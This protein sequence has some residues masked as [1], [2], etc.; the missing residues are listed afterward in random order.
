MHAHASFRP[1]MRNRFDQLTKLVTRKAYSPGGMV[2]TDAEVSPDAKRIDI[3]FTPDPTLPRSILDAILDPLGLLGRI[4]RTPVTIEP[5][6]EPPDGLE[7]MDCVIKHHIFRRMLAARDPAP[8]LPR[9]WILSA[10]R[11]SLALAG[12]WFRKSRRWGPGIY[13][14]PPLTYT[15]LV[16]IREL[17]VRRDTLLVRLMGAGSTLRKA[18]A[19]LD[20]LPEDAPERRVAHQ[21]LL[22]LG[23]EATADATRRTKEDEEFIMA[24]QEIVE[25][26]LA[27]REEQGRQQGRKEELIEALLAV[28]KARFGETPR[29]IVTAVES[30]HDMSVLR[31]WR[32]LVATHSADEIAAA[33]CAP[34]ARPPVPARAAIKKR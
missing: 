27:E 26:F 11:P 22:D 30:T 9:Q 8:P 33:L 10:G 6:H 32:D 31:R 4:G 23:V 20:A 14:A 7:L 24:T 2:E 3:W 5:F 21:T 1:P 16:V 13:D 25:K 12:L 17:P 18:V 29:S 15:K 34:P 19:E 28:Y